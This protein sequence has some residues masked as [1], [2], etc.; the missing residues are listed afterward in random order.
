MP[1][2]LN[3]HQKTSIQIEP[4]RSRARK[5]MRALG[6]FIVKSIYLFTATIVATILWFLLYG[7]LA[8]TVLSNAIPQSALVVGVIFLA[9]FIVLFVRYR[10]S[11]K[12]VARWTAKTS[13][14]IMPFMVLGSLS[15]FALALLPQNADDVASA[16]GITGKSSSNREITITQNGLLTATNTACQQNNKGDLRLSERLNQSALSRCRDMVANNYWNHND[17][18]GREPWRFFQDAGYDFSTAGENLAYG[19]Y[20]N[21]ETV[22]GWMESP[23]HREHILKDYTEVGFGICKSDNYVGDGMQTIVVQHFGVPIVNSL[24]SSTKP[25][26]AESFSGVPNPVASQY[27]ASVCTKKPLPRGTDYVEV[28]YMYVGDTKRYEG[29]DGYIESCTADSNGYK[30]A[31]YTSQ[32]HNDTVYVGV[33]VRPVYSTTPP[34]Y[35]SCNQFSGTSAEFACI[36]AI[37]R[38]RNP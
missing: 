8:N 29:W 14:I 26:Y 16:G 23:T 21:K 15:L 6:L 18:H 3:K 10:K 2:L 20:T 17:N 32:P 12:A 28:D 30:P 7:L 13:M 1:R 34:N 36:Q 9:V 31:D 25:S 38:S 37:N 11:S 35:S 24:G 5:M 33:G 4:E 22:T 27:V 19:F